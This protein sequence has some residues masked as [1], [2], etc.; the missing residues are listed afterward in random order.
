M[1]MPVHPQGLAR[2]K[3]RYAGIGLEE[4]AIGDLV[5]VGGQVMAKGHE[6]VAAAQKLQVGIGHFC[7]WLQ[8]VV[9]VPVFPKNCPRLPP[10]MADCAHLQVA[11]RLVSETGSTSISAAE[12]LLVR[13]RPP[14][15]DPHL[16]LLHLVL[17]DGIRSFRN[18]HTDKALHDLMTPDSHQ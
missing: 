15:L 7:K 9:N 8:K 2:W 14:F 12:A 6:L 1:P 11:L 18:H 10:F 17:S 4:D 13:S 16:H 5:S 3:E